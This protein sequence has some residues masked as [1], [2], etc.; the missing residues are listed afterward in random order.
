[1]GNLVP[2]EII[3]YERVENKIYARYPGRP[4]IPRWLIG[5]TE[6]RILGYDDWKQML[7]LS[8]SNPTFKRELDKVINL[9]YLLKESK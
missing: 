7:L 1:L 4:D 2:D 3:I 9:Y 5:E 8:D 6:P